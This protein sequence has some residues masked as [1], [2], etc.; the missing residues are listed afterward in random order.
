MVAANLE[1]SRREY[2]E[3]QTNGIIQTQKEKRIE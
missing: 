3:E 1:A 2:A